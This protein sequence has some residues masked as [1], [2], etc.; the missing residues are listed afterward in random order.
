MLKKKQLFVAS[1]SDVFFFVSIFF[2]SRRYWSAA[3]HR[4]FQ[5]VLFESSELLGIKAVASGRKPSERLD[6]KNVRRKFD[7]NSIVKAGPSST[8][9]IP[10]D[11]AGRSAQIGI[12]N[13]FPR[14]GR[15]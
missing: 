6:F 12:S 11:L 8:G 5:L 10:W 13:N 14:T 9:A 7:G 4:S 3:F 2:R 1:G 15:T